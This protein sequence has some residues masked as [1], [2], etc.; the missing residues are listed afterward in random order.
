MTVEYIDI[1]RHGSTLSGNI[2]RGHT[3]DPLS[4]EGFVQMQ[5][6]V[7]GNAWRRIITSPLSRCRRFAEELSHERRIP[8]AVDDRLTEFHFGEWDGRDVDLL[9]AEDGER[10][11]RFFA[12]PVNNTPPGGEEFQSFDRRVQDAWRSIHDDDQSGG[13]LIITHGGVILSILAHV[14]GRDRLHGRVDVPYACISR[15]ARGGADY[16]ARLLYHGHGP[17]RAN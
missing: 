10:L 1:L 13:T 3:D 6:A 15:I 14:L 11:Q 4:E 8:L 9:R 12:D 5:T 17:I 16:P 2:L 7:A